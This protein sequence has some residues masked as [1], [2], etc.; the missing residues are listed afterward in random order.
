MCWFWTAQQPNHHLIHAKAARWYV[1]AASD[2]YLW[3]VPVP[4]L[5]A[6][7]SRLKSCESGKPTKPL[8]SVKREPSDDHEF[9]R[10][11]SKHLE[12]SLA[13]DPKKRNR[14]VFCQSRWWD[15]DDLMIWSKA[16]C[17][18]WQNLGEKLAESIKLLCKTPLLFAPAHRSH[19][20]STESARRGLWPRNHCPTPGKVALGHVH[21]IWKIR[22]RWRL[23]AFQFH[24]QQKAAICLFPQA[25]CFE[26]A[27][28]FPL[29]ANMRD[30]QPSGRI[31]FWTPEERKFKEKGHSPP[32]ITLVEIASPHKTSLN[33]CP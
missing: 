31:A 17:Q 2:E 15:F 4:S 33:Q 7:A 25:A 6:S 5:V 14:R 27:W 20:P 18:F 11:T 21:Q 3:D 10:C 1:S 24:C 30:G 26:I 32:K 19:R 12:N 16:M 28:I 9:G 29:I 22:W 8:G 23:L 13:F